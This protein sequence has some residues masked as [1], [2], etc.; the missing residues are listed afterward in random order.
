MSALE[1]IIRGIK[2]NEVLFHTEEL[3]LPLPDENRE[4]FSRMA[5]LTLWNSLRLRLRLRWRKS[6]KWLADTLLE[7][8]GLS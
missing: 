4:A 8:Y 6:R 1:L 3:W 2:P 7:P 5:E